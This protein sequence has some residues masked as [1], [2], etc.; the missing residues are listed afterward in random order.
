MY[1]L[2]YETFELKNCHGP[3]HENVLSFFEEYCR[4]DLRRRHLYNSLQR[5]K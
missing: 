3:D 5:A 2:F 4:E 1:G